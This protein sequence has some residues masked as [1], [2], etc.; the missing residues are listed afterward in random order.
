MAAAIRD[1]QANGLD[2]IR[3]SVHPYGYLRNGDQWMLKSTIV[4]VLVLAFVGWMI[5]DSSSFKACVQ[6]HQQQ[7]AEDT[8]QDKIAVFGIAFERY[9]DCLGGFIHDNRDDLLT[10]F[11]IVLAVS[12]ILLWVATRDLANEAARSSRLELRTYVGAGHPKFGKPDPTEVTIDVENGGRTPAYRITGWLNAYSIAGENNALP[13]G[14][15]FPDQAQTGAFPVYKSVAVLHPAKS[16]PFTFIFDLAL[17]E[18]CRRKDATLF[19]YG[20][21]DYVDIFD[22]P[23]VSQ[24]CYQ[25]FPVEVGIGH[26]LVMY[27]EH[28]EAT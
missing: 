16:A 21:I 23:H 20:H 17:I 2:G 26:S 6:Q 19:I 5:A 24:F 15:S 27:D 7:T 11:T 12:T 22:R 8:F 18:R 1:H 14:F 28:N 4:G 9:R 3:C 10:I 25:Y 13:D